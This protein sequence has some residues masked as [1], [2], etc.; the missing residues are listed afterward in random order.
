V[1]LIPWLRARARNSST[2]LANPCAVVVSGLDARTTAPLR[3][4][5]LVDVIGLFAQTTV[6]MAHSIVAPTNIRRLFMIYPPAF[7]VA[8][9]VSLLPCHDPSAF[10]DTAKA[11]CRETRGLSRVQ[12]MQQARTSAPRPRHFALDLVLLH[13]GLG[14]FPAGA[15]ARR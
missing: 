12:A 8:C 11:L 7:P 6:D 14:P 1:A 9:P 4:A 13:L 10:M 2:Q 15:A 3:S 5:G